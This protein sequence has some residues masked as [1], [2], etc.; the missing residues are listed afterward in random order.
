MDR[1]RYAGHV[2]QEQLNIEGVKPNTGF[3]HRPQMCNNKGSHSNVDVTGFPGNIDSKF[4]KL[5]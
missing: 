4:C 5:T 2:P 1:G 3:G